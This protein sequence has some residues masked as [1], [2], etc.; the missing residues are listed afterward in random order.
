MALREAP[1]IKAA[2]G[3]APAKELL[4]E[5]GAEDS[6]NHGSP[7]VL[8]KKGRDN[9]NLHDEFIRLAESRLAQTALMLL[10][11]F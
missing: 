4:P 8:E 1:R 5:R 3:P 9:R 11:C 10:Q 7:W 2:R 6:A